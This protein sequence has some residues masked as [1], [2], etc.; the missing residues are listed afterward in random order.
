MAVVYDSFDRGLHSSEPVCI[1]RSEGSILGAASAEDSP[2]S[3]ERVVGAP[4]QGGNLRAQRRHVEQT[5]AGAAI[6]V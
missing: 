2:E 6:L 3:P 4:S 1:V 5:T